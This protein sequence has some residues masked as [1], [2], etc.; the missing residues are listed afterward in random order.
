MGYCL[1]IF[2]AKLSLFILY[3]QIFSPSR[4][5]RIL[6]HVGIASIFVVYAG[7]IVGYW[8]L[9]VPKLGGSW[10]ESVIA[11][12]C[13]NE[14]LKFG[15]IMGPFG[16]ISDFYLLFIPISIILRLQLPLGKKIVAFAIFMTGFL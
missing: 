4:K 7:F 12:K 16:V 6:I 13:S 11:S 1:V 2:F 10:W 15:Y 3:F 5:T 8:V 9:C 14:T